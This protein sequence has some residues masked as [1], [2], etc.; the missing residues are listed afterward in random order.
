MSEN[1]NQKCPQCGAEMPGG[2]MGRVCPRCA[3][4]FLKA[5]P[6][7]I[8]GEPSAS[9]RP[10][11]PPRVAE[12]APLFPQLE[13][14]ELIGQGGMGAVY[15]ARQKELDRIVA[16]KI[17]PPG[18]GGADFAERFAR[19][20]KALARLNHPGI[21]TLYEF[22]R[23]DGL[24]FFLMEY[25]DG[26]TLRQVLHGGR[27]S[28]REALAIVPAICDALQYAH[29]QGIVHRDI[30]PENILLDRR[31]RTKV[32][33]FGL[34]KLMESGGAVSDVDSSAPAMASA[35]TQAGKV[36]GTPQYMA[37]E[38]VEHPA[39]VDHRADI[40][41]LGVVFY[42]ML[43]GEL[44]GKRVEAPSTKVQI[45]VRLDEVV[46]RAL[47]KNPDRRYGQ[48]SQIKTAV[49]T[50]AATEK[51]PGAS[52]QPPPSGVA[53]PS[54]IGK[55]PR[56][57]ATA[58]SE[59]SLRAAR[60]QAVER[61][62][63]LPLRLMVIIFVGYYFFFA[64]WFDVYGLRGAP[65]WVT[66]NAA[67]LKGWL[68]AYAL[69]TVVLGILICTKRLSL[70]RIAWVVFAG[71]VL[72]CILMAALTFVCEPSGFDTKLYLVFAM[73]ILHNAWSIPSAFPQ[74][75][76]NFLTIGSFVAGGV[77]DTAI[78]PRAPVMDV[79]SM[80]HE[81]PV[82]RV[83]VLLT[84]AICCCVIQVLFDKRKPGEA[85]L[86]GPGRATPSAGQKTAPGQSVIA[87]WKVF[88]ILALL[89]L[90]YYLW[91]AFRASTAR[92]AALRARAQ[93]QGVVR[94]GQANLVS[95][96]A[97]RTGD[98]GVRIQSLGTV[99]SS[100]S[101]VFTIAENSCQEVIRKFDAH[102]TL[103]VEATNSQGEKF[104]HGFLSGVDNVIDT[105]TG[106]L[107][108][109]ATLIPE[110]ENLMV[111]GFFLTV[112]LLL[113]MKHGVTLVAT[114]AVQRDAQSAF[115][116]VI[117]ADQTVRRRTVRVG[118][119]DVDWTEI[120][121]GLSPGEMVASSGFNHLSEGQK[122]HHYFLVV[123]PESVQASG[124]G[125]L[126]Y[127]WLFNSTNVTAATN[128]VQK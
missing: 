72:D 23:S 89:M 15:K 86:G 81:N 2:S 65:D 58:A 48:A 100:N 109:K 87:V 40:Y 9:R 14:L 34:A 35:A 82:E 124:N 10:F 84:W 115:V 13:I 104:G 26:A 32:A 22:G 38:Q 108:C 123:K 111:P 5:D 94:N 18:V 52:P 117:Q 74:L 113:E 119:I 80:L 11:T 102:Q 95:A 105:S 78:N 3:A 4:A 107:K 39:S 73:L 20:A 126:T 19:E 59:P 44:P 85:E 88:S 46:L 49:E 56:L 121:S 50:I 112:S 30:K 68:V 37:P 97:A 120:Q 77:L 93:V 79:G 60:I 67:L 33:D 90:S 98:I 29:D 127:Q 69:L 64:G 125:P 128:A 27:I 25:V 61:D 63:V 91:W 116:W 122:I 8:T 54:T 62:I 51:Q 101:I 75:L 92:S 103:A 31:G 17:L 16:L 43:T 118:T 47:E 110:G 53:D 71:G 66:E 83:V 7:E 70:P 57:L 1:A 99:E 55:R 45:D 41:A 28:P 96:T 24:F 106:T 76:L 12:L 21:V 36:L 42:Q 6:S 114:A